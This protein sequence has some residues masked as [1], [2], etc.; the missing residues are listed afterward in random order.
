MAELAASERG[1]ASAG[2]TLIELLIVVAIIGI[3]AAIAIPQFGNYRKRTYNA[4]AQSDLS[5]VRY[6]QE[7]MNAEFQDYGASAVSSGDLV[8]VGANTNNIQNT[9]L[10]AGVSVGVKVLA[11]A[12]Q[13]ISYCAAAKHLQGDSAFGIETETAGISRLLILSSVALTNTD[14]PAATVAVDLVTPWASL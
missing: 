5:N 4:A 10:S 3:L 2:F 12:G 8:L 7:T 13:H 1:P 14:I 11:N 6:V 9:R